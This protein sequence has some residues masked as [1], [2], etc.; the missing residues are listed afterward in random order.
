MDESLRSCC[1]TARSSQH[2]TC[3][4]ILG[5]LAA[6]THTLSLSPT[7]A[8]IPPPVYLWIKTRS[9]DLITL[10]ASSALNV[11]GLPAD[12]APR[13][14]RLL[15]RPRTGTAHPVPS[16][17]LP[18]PNQRRGGGCG[19]YLGR[20]VETARAWRSLSKQCACRLSAEVSSWSLA[21]WWWVCET[22]V[23]KM[24][25]DSCC[26]GG[27]TGGSFMLCER[28]KL[29]FDRPGQ[30]ASDPLLAYSGRSLGN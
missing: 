21:W 14:H 1:H 7:L 20:R 17:L 23:W 5:H 9:P 28:W 16:W 27:P 22:V 3:V 8:H 13:T 15:T 4:A 11:W 30:R 18:L 29:A 24:A 2:H 12:T 6:A 26:C 10:T 25:V 19:V